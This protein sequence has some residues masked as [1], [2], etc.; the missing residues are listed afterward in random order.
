MKSEEKDAFG[1]RMKLYEGMETDRMFMPLLPIIARLDG[2]SFH[3]FTKD[4]DRPFDKFLHDTMVATTKYLVQETGACM[5][6]TQSDEITLAFYSPEITS[7]VWFNGRIFKM[8][9]QLSAQTTVY[10]NYLLNQKSPYYAARLPTFDARVWQVPNLM[11]GSNVFLW[12]EQDASKNSISMA[13]SSF[14]SHKELMNKTGQQKQEMLFIKG[15]NWNDY[16]AC[17]KRGQ[18]VQRRTQSIPFTT[19]KIELLPAKHEARKNP[20]LMVERTTVT[21]IDMPIFSTVTNRVDVVFHGATP[22][23]VSDDI[24]QGMQR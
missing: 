14:F 2:R 15:I 11:E 1:E 10:F 17:Y 22:V 6:Y 23:V 5:G 4:M 8:V 13:A 19:A 12:R 18:F 7:Q 9:S 16:A 24:Q 20:A 21:L 3:N